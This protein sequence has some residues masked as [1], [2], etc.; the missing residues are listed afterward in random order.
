MDSAGTALRNATAVL[1]AS[2]AN[3]IAQDSQQWSRWL[4]VGLIR[5]AIHAQGNH[6]SLS[7]CEVA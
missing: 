1:C 3:A 4:S 2:Q 6:C 7:F 5:F